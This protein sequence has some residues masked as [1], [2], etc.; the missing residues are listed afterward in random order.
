MSGMVLPM[1]TMLALL[2]GGPA[3]SANL[4]YQLVTASVDIAAS[5]SAGGP[6]DEA[7]WQDSVSFEQVPGWASDVG[8]MTVEGSGDSALAF[9]HMQSQADFSGSGSAT[10]LVASAAG[11]SLGTATGG[12]AGFGSQCEDGIFSGSSRSSFDV[13]FTVDADAAFSFSGSSVLAD[14][15]YIEFYVANQ[16]PYGRLFSLG[17]GEA[18]S[19]SG[20]LQAGTLYGIRA[21]SQVSLFGATDAEAWTFNLFH[22]G[23]Q[24]WDFE[25]ELVPVPIPA[26]AW[27]FGGA[28]AVLRLLR[29]KSAVT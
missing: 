20:I 14:D 5:A 25:L 22:E 1:L 11:F 4:Q 27:L 18:G 19:F 15:G 21:L 8:P 12:C 9:A 10:H 13:A 23:L 28:L 17:N 26:A 24:G 6:P 16:P 2:T 7:Q 3:L 29:R